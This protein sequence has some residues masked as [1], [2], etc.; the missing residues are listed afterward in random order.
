MKTKEKILDVV[1]II[2]QIHAAHGNEKYKIFKKHF[3]NTK[4]L[5][6]A[7]LDNSHLIS[8]LPRM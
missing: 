7:G 6:N 5:R 4:I 3:P 8:M 2:N 1:S